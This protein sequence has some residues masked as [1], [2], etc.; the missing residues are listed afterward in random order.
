MMDPRLLD[1]GFT[2]KELARRAGMQGFRPVADPLV[3][4]LGAL[5][6]D[7]DVA[8]LMGADPFDDVADPIGGPMGGYQDTAAELHQLCDRIVRTVWPS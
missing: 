4:W 2:V 8:A 3:A 6:A 5:V 7:R 1:A